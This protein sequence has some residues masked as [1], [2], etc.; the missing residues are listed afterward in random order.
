MIAHDSDARRRR[1]PSRNESGAPHSPGMAA[2]EPDP[3]RSSQRPLHPLRECCYRVLSLPLTQQMGDFNSQPWSIPINILRKH[4]T[5]RDSFIDANPSAED[6]PSSIEAEAALRISGMTCDSTLN[7]W[8][9]AKNI[10]GDVAARGG[11]RLDYIFYREPEVARR[12]PLIW[13]YRDEPE[14]ASAAGGVNSDAAGVEEGKPLPSSVQHAPT[15]R[16]VRSEVVLTE[17]VPGHQFSY[18]DHFGLFSTF[19]IDAPATTKRSSGLRN[20]WSSR[21]P[22][23]SPPSGGSTGQ[24]SFTPLLPMMSEP[25]PLSATTTTFARPDPPKDY[26]PDSPRPSASL[27]AKSTVVRTALDVLRMYTKV[28]QSRS[29]G[30]L[31]W[32]GAAVVCLVGL[33]IGSAWQ[34]KSWIQPIFTLLAGAL[35]AGG[36]TYLYWGFLWGRWE[37]GL[38]TEA[39]EEMELELRVVEMEER[40]SRF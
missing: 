35:G 6:P 32:F 3:E 7:T 12:R 30:H 11:K 24:N 28:S 22:S 10:P 25:E 20:S 36:A 18:S 14:H 8:S 15:M 31:R 23:T 9:A 26:G 19:Q 2:R 1:R 13:G 40:I 37:M 21:N 39:I 16:C 29:R 33:T 34:P 38:L 17:L 5:M 4:A 27:T